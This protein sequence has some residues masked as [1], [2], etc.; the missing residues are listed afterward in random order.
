MPICVLKRGDLC[1]HMSS[2]EN[3]ARFRLASQRGK[4]ARQK[5]KM[6]TNLDLF[7][8]HLHRQPNANTKL[9]FAVSHRRPRVRSTGLIWPGVFGLYCTKQTIRPYLKYAPSHVGPLYSAGHEHSN[10]S[11]ISVHDP[12]F[13]QGLGWHLFFSVKKTIKLEISIEIGIMISRDMISYMG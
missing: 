2:S 1:D 5:S 8:M 4:F 6:A 11:S 3:D 12:P 10:P 9:D 7:R 13:L